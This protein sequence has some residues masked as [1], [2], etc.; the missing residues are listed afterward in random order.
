MGQVMSFLCPYL[1]EMCHL[2]ESV[3]SDETCI[4]SR[5]ADMNF[6]S[7]STTTVARP[8]AGGSASL[9]SLHNTTSQLEED[10]ETYCGRE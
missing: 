2:C 9:C 10:F 4:A 3:C 6:I 8:E 5:I 1:V 7:S